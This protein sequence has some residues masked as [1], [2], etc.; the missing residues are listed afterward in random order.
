MGLD[1]YINKFFFL[2]I[3]TRQVIQS[4]IFETL[5][6]VCIHLIMFE[7]AMS[8]HSYGHRVKSILIYIK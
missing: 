3:L 6:N 2:Y 5:S 1:G 8:Y 7:L 4:A